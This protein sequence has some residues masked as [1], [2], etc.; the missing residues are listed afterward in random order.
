VPGEKAVIGHS[1]KVGVDVLPTMIA[2]GYSYRYNK[3]RKDLIAGEIGR[4]QKKQPRQP[5][6]KHAFCVNKGKYHSSATEEEKKRGY[7]CC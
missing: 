6:P 4:N 5:K 7:C 3:K 2:N 1:R